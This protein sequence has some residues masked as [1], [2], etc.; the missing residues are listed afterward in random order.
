MFGLEDKQKE[1][2]AY[3]IEKQFR[4]DEKKSKEILTR[5]SEHENE[6]A[7]LLR[8]ESNDKDLKILLEGYKAL[9]KVIQKIQKR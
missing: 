1:P 6:V 9:P 3:D 5:L 4:K 8:K 7:G 2:F